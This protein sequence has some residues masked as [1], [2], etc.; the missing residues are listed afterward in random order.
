MVSHLLNLSMAFCEDARQIGESVC[1]VFH[2][3]R[4][5][6]SARFK[7]DG[8][9]AAREGNLLARRHVPFDMA[10]HAERSREL[11]LESGLSAH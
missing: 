2:A 7:L 8:Q 5:G 3:G 10:R 9:L 11:N 1:G 6:V 4:I